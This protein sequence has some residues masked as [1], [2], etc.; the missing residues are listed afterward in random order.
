MRTVFDQ[1]VQPEIV[2][3]VLEKF[4]FGI[5][6]G[7]GGLKLP[8]RVYDC[9]GDSRCWVSGAMALKLRKVARRDTT[10]GIEGEIDQSGKETN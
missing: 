9:P 1:I 8:E 4:E 10:K 7:G 6:V 5:V 2:G 3:V